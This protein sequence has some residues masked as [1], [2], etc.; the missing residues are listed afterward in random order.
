M[1]ITNLRIWILTI[2]VGILFVGIAFADEL[3]HLRDYPHPIICK[4]IVE[5]DGVIIV[6]P[7]SE[8]IVLPWARLES[9]DPEKLVFKTKDGLFTM[10]S[11]NYVCTMA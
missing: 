3:D 4:P 6:S 10:P 11:P 1:K 7:Q 5:K 2:A 8:W 9:L